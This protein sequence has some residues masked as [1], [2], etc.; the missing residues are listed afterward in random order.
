MV[1]LICVVS[2]LSALDRNNSFPSYVHRIN[3]WFC[4]GFFLWVFSAEPTMSLA[5]LK[6]EKLTK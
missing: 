1:R 4:L 3:L 5:Q 6:P 2:G